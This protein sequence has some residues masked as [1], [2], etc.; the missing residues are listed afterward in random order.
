M[1]FNAFHIPFSFS[2][3]IGTDIDTVG[4]DYFPANPPSGPKLPYH[5][6]TIL[7]T[8]NRAWLLL[9]MAVTRQDC[10]ISGFGTI[11]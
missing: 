5:P 2:F 8:G 7:Y 1:R 9:S 4:R 6:N 3:T 11:I 10:G